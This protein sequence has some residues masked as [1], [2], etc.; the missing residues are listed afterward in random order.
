MPASA[1]LCA[2]VRHA[3]L[4]APLPAWSIS[5]SVTLALLVGSACL[6]VWLKY[7]ARKLNPE[8]AVFWPTWIA[9]GTVAIGGSVI[10]GLVR[11]L[12]IPVLQVVLA[13]GSILFGFSV[14]PKILEKKGYDPATGRV[15]NWWWIVLAHLWAVVILLSA[16]AVGVEIYD[17]S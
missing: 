7:L 11:N 5:L 4:E 2:V 1:N 15:I 9:T 3:L 6:E 8:D 16:V 12:N 14:L 13:F 10:D 17:F